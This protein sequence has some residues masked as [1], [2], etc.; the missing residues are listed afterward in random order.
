M[1][2]IAHAANDKRNIAA[3]SSAN[4]ASIDALSPA[5]L[6]QLAH[7]ARSFEGDDATS[8]VVLSGRYRATL[9]MRQ[10]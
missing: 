8:V 6:R 9:A 4:F 10:A 2:V 5:A 3:V 7:A 1:V